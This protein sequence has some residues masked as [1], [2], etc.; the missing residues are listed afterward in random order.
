MAL[1]ADMERRERLRVRLLLLP[2]LRLARCPLSLSAVG[3]S[4]GPQSWA[5]T[6]EAG[7]VPSGQPCGGDTVP[8]P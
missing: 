1:H 5:L 7:A 2:G 3:T 4:A 8:C 6:A